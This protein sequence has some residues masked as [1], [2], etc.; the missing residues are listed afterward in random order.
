MP[1]AEC[2]DAVL[3]MHLAQEGMS[4]AEAEVHL[5]LLE[6]AAPDWLEIGDAAAG[7]SGRQR[8]VTI[9]KM[10]TGVRRRLEDVAHGYA[11]V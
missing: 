2:V 5:R 3:A 6:R 11:H 4:A 10:C 9:G 1:Y 7:K 8:T